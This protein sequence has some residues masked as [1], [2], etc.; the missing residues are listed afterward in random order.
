MRIR[1]SVERAAERGGV[2]FV[3]SMGFLEAG[4]LAI[5]LTV[6]GNAF[7]L[8]RMRWVW[9]GNPAPKRGGGIIESRGWAFGTREPEI[10]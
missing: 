1:A 7:S 9:G 3:W 6:I 5:V 8:E 10:G 2:D 4:V